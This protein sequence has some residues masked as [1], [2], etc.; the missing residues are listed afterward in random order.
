LLTVDEDNLQEKTA[1]I[2]ETLFMD[3]E[4]ISHEIGRVIPRQ[5]KLMGEMGM[6]FE[7][8]VKRIYP[9][10]PFKQRIESGMNIFLILILISK[11]SWSDFMMFV[12][13]D[14]KSP[15]KQCFFCLDAGSS[16]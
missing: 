3:G 16:C 4:R 11:N 13:T 1:K 2:L 10:F 14:S 9:E 7:D 5:L 6:T 8:E 12:E 15:E